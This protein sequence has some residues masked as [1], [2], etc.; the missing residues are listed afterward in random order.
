MYNIASKVAPP[1]AIDIAPLRIWTFLPVTGQIISRQVIV[2]D[3]SNVKV[4]TP[5]K[6][7]RKESAPS[8]Q[9]P[10]TPG[11]VKGSGSALGTKLPTVT[12]PKCNIV[13]PGKRKNKGEKEE[14]KEDEE[15]DEDDDGEQDD[16]EET[17]VEDELAKLEA[18]QAKGRKKKATEESAKKKPRV[19]KE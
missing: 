9:S 6:P 13:T 18:M 8:S 16:S 15:D 10:E 17:N 7:Q 14:E 2:E 19:K 5:G 11:D 3:G 12:Q 1:T 4:T